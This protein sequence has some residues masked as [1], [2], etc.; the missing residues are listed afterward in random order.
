MQ[1]SAGRL[2][3]ALVLAGAVG[4]ELLV[5]AAFTRPEVQPLVLVL[6]A[7]LPHAMAYLFLLWLFG[8]TLQPGREALI[9]S[10][11]RRFHGSLPPYME[12]YTHK[13]TGMW[14]LFF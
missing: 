4:Y 7:G 10:V 11:A 8:R 3:G 14:C 2:G 12:A 9:T 13:L 6:L 5:H 1:I